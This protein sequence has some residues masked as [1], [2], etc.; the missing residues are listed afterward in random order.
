ESDLES[1]ALLPVGETGRG[2]EAVKTVLRFGARRVS[3][4]CQILS[5]LIVHFAHER[6]QQIP[7][8]RSARLGMTKFEVLVGITSARPYTQSEER[9]PAL[10]KAHRRTLAPAFSLCFVIPN[11]LQQER[12]L[13]CSF[14]RLAPNR[15]R[16]L[17][18]EREQQIP[19]R[20]S[21]ASE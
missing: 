11:L 4:R 16:I 20:R 6:E 14:L 12:N 21:T 18:H 17:P 19:R 5:R 8:R 1:R 10:S 2:W 13:L 7:R 15:R 9:F 3:V